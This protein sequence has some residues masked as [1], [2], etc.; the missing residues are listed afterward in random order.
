MPRIA[1]QSWPLLHAAVD[2][3]SART[4]RCRRG[5][6]GRGTVRRPHTDRGKL[7]RVD[8]RL[9]APVD[10]RGVAAIEHLRAPTRAEVVPA[11]VDE[12]VDPVAEPGH[13]R[14][15][16]AEPRSEGDLPLELVVV[17]D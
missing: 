16:D 3:R 7:R 9:I 12:R 14:G 17:A 4:G 2:G 1:P 15:V 5:P 11:P 6:V 8:G 13:Q 10:P